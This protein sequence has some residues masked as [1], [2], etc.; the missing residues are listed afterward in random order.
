[1]STS[2]LAGKRVI[3]RVDFN[4]PLDKKGKIIDDT[5]ILATLPTI[6][7]LQ[8]KEAKVILCS[9]NGRP[10][11]QVRAKFSLFPLA[12]KLSL[13]LGIN[14]IWCD[15]CLGVEVEEILSGL[16]NG[17]VALLENLRFYSE[18]EEN[19]SDFTFALAQL[20]DLYVMDA[21]G[22]AH[23]HHASTVGITEYFDICVGGKLVEK[24]INYLQQIKDNP[25]RPLA[26]IIG[27]GKLSSKISVI[28]S[29]LDCCDKILLGGGLIYTFYAA[30]GLT[31][32]DSHL[33]R[34][35]LE[36]ADYLISAAPKKGVELLLPIDVVVTNTL[37]KK[38]DYL[39]VS[40][41]QIPEGWIGVD[42]GQRSVKMFEKALF[43]CKTIVWNGALG[44]FKLSQFKSGTSSLAN[45]LGFLSKIQKT[46][47][48]IAGG[49]L[50]S[51]INEIGI[52]DQMSYISSGGGST[53]NYISG[54][55]LPALAAIS[56]I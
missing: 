6:K 13:L 16:K 50:I 46:T 27:G 42:I 35:Y 4:V 8:E 48:I 7:Y 11:G 5:R 54:K 31:V 25:R 51:A 56:Q 9:H 45:Y 20:G 49:N 21:F 26:A 47:T 23:R 34:D 52:G 38:G 2:E 14:V 36:L 17:Q 12:E 22:T 53:L 32:G 1:L 40:P 39:T 43:N 3:V 18:E 15:D 28:E 29:L 19:D 55:E 41:E 30:R 37:T 10:K 24:E 33:A 44:M